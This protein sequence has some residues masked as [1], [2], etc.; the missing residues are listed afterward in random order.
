MAQAGTFVVPEWVG[1]PPESLPTNLET[2]G[3]R[4]P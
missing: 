3:A 2:I 4:P 1:A